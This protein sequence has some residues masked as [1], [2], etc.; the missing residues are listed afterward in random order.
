[1]CY[2]MDLWLLTHDTE[3]K[4]CDYVQTEYEYAHKGTRKAIGRAARRKATA[5]AKRRHVETAK[6]RKKHATKAERDGEMVYIFHEWKEVAAIHDSKLWKPKGKREFT[7]HNHEYCFHVYYDRA[8][9]RATETVYVT[10]DGESDAC[11]KAWNMYKGN[12]LL[13][14]HLDRAFMVEDFDETVF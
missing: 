11:H 3:A 1:M 14:P 2:E 6:L 10:A 4:A 8:A 12:E 9:K 5:K 13:W 7:K